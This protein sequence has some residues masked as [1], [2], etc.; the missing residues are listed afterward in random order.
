MRR[1]EIEEAEIESAIQRPE[2][3]QPSLEGRMNAWKEISGRFLRVTYKEEK[4][5][6]LVISAVRKRKG[7]G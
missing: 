6:I 4:D 2:F 7:W 3:L 5:R 1:H